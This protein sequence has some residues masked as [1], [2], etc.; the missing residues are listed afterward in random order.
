M[1]TM[2]AN[3][4]LSPTAADSAAATRAVASASDGSKL[5]AS[6]SGMGKMVR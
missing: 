4:H 3:V 2:G 1:S 5:A 6:P